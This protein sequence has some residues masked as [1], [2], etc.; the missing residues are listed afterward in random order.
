MHDK[1]YASLQA[2]KGT[3]AFAVIQ[4][5]HK[6]ARGNKLLMIPVFSLFIISL[7]ASAQAIRNL[8][9]HD[10]L[11]Q[12]GRCYYK[13]TRCQRNEFNC[14]CEDDISGDPPTCI[15]QSSVCDGQLD[16]PNSADEIDCSCGLGQFQCYGGGSVR[17]HQCIDER[18][19]NDDK[20]DCVN[21]R[22]YIS[23]SKSFQCADGFYL[24][25]SRK[26]DGHDDCYDNS[27]EANCTDCPELKCHCFDGEVNSCGE[28]NRCF[29]Y[30]RKCDGYANCPDGSDE[31]NCSNSCSTENSLRCAC[32]KADRYTCQGEG[33]VC[34]APDETCNGYA[35]CPDGSDEWNCSSPCSKEA[36]LRCA[37]NKLHSYTC[38]GEGNVCYAQEERCDTKIQDK[39][40]NVCVDLSDEVDCTCPEDSFTCSC[41]RKKFPTCSIRT[42]C[43]PLAR[44]NDGQPDCESGN[45]EQFIKAWERV[46]CGF[47]DVNLYRLESEAFCRPPW[48]DNKTCYSIP[49]SHCK[50]N[51]C[52]LTD[53]ICT[54]HC[55]YNDSSGNCDIIMQCSDRSVILNQNFCNGKTDCK[56]GSDEI[57]F[58]PGFKCSSKFSPI[59]CVLPQWNLYDNIAQCYDKSDLCFSDDGSL[60]C[61]QCLDKRLIISPKQLCDGTIDCYDLSDE[62]LC[63]NPTL[64]ECIDIFAK[65]PRCSRINSKYVGSAPGNE[66]GTLCSGS[67][68][69][70]SSKRKVMFST[71]CKNKHGDTRASMCDGR[72]ECTD[73]SDECVSCPNSPAFCNSTCRSYFAMGDRFCDGYVD[74]SW[75]FLQFTDCSRG[76][77]EVD[78]PKRFYCRA[79]R[80]LSIDIMQ[81]CDGRENC[82]MGID[83]VNCTDRHYCTAKANGLKSIPK[84]LAPNGKVDCVDGSDE[85]IP[86]V[87]SSAYN[88]IDNLGLKLWLWFATTLTILG[89]IYIF[90]VYKVNLKKKKANAVSSCNHILLINLAFSDGL[91][92]IYLFIILIKDIQLSGIYSEF[93]YEW[94]SSFLCSFAGSLCVIS[95]ETSCFLMV[96]LTMYRLFAV[97]FPHRVDSYSIVTWKVAAFFSWIIS[98]FIAITTNF[99]P[100]FKSK[101]IF[102]NDFS[103][104]DTVSFEHFSD[105]T[106]RLAV[107]TNTSNDFDDSSW[108][109]IQSFLE[110]RFPQYASKGVIG[111][112]GT[113]SVCMPTL[114][115][116]QSDPFWMFSLVIVTLNLLSFFFILTGFSLI[117]YKLRKSSRQSNS[118]KSRHI[119]R[120][121]RRIARVIITDFLCWFPI[122]LMAYVSMAGVELPDGV[123]IFTAGV[124]LPINSALNPM[125]YSDY[126]EVK[127]E[128]LRKRLFGQRGRLSSMSTTGHRSTIE[129]Q[130][131]KQIQD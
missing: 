95:S 50:D 113:S 118:T 72:P 48:C 129:L 97:W 55:S 86:G 64:P 117:V 49:S 28:G 126:I 38:E 122:C 125:L 111:Y 130:T 112:Y 94:R 34:Y 85:Y 25:L 123:E 68:C 1:R 46:R 4:D 24:P 17:L 78:C 131:L 82:D 8:S 65:S 27:D 93:D 12:S 89:N 71:V 102:P 107:L 74:E 20:I 37:C 119:T 120:M 128:R 77:D 98:I 15:P 54:S 108:K 51:R 10:V 91:M 33:Y 66:T 87:F 83:E 9:K 81:R 92:G 101:V 114:Y 14:R 11:I 26:C 30:Y 42:G 43:I 6:Q 62:C 56:D 99:A 75:K 39:G 61:F 13:P 67:L 18:R 44:V 109:T 40:D 63:D 7:L 19:V 16:C 106:C 58:K 2:Q 32:N 76:F 79:G 121:N 31:W 127:V 45:D 88:M 69:E 47:C 80:M 3:V 22:D 103:P 23:E 59:S 90:F 110:K 29:P 36:P 104:S 57:V 35:K 105:F 73:F 115:V 124:L 41:F 5:T 96:I 70:N 53:A 52:N 60:L 84:I 116:S 100:Y 21:L